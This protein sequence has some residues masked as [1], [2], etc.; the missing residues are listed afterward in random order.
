MTEFLMIFRNEYTPE[1]KP[2]PEQMQASVKE[3]QDWMG[4]IAAQ[5]KFSGTNRLS[6][7]GSK[8][9][10]PNAVITDGPYIEMKEIVGGYLLVKV[11]SMSEAI[12]LAEGCPIYAMGGNVE[13]REVI[14]MNY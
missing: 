4:S 7:V 1:Y 12:K 10:R 9:I 8:I 13:L 6:S 5:G 14:P 2:T 3:W 11:D